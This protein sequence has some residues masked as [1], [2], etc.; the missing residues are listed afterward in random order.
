[1]LL[2]LSLRNVFVGFFVQALLCLQLVLEC[3]SVCAERIHLGRG[4][5]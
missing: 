1:M 2:R 5:P 3:V 4:I